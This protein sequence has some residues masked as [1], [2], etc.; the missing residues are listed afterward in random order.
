MARGRSAA[1]IIWTWAILALIVSVSGVLQRVPFP[2]PQVFVGALALLFFLALVFSSGMRAW[3]RGLSLH[4]LT[5]I[6]IWR[7][8]P[9]ITFLILHNRRMLAGAFA[10]PAGWGDIIVGVSAPFFAAFFVDRGRPALLLWHVGAM[11]DLAIAVASAA[12]YAMGQPLWLDSLRHFPLSLLPLFLV[13][14]T[15]MIHIAALYLILRRY[16]MFREEEQ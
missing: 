13:P 5:L 6:H 14:I 9:G 2:Y 11:I 1:P 10:V 12:G 15:L 16:G 4:T 7:V 8:L 3:A